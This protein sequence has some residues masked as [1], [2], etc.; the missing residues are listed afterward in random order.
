MKYYSMLDFHHF[1][2]RRH[3]QRRRELLSGLLVRRFV[4]LSRVLTNWVL[5]ELLL[6]VAPTL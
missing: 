2:A 5:L 6:L 4:G 1:Y 3:F